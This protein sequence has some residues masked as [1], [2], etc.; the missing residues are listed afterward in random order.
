MSGGRIDYVAEFVYRTP[1]EPEPKVGSRHLDLLRLYDRV[2]GEG[3]YDMVS[4]TREKPLMWRKIAEEFIGTGQYI[5]AQAFQVKS[6]YYKFL[7]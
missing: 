6:V 2:I 1:F 7:A 4:N 5:G 3:G